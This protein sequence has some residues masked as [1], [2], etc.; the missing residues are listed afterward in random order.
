MDT[1]DGIMALRQALVD[2]LYDLD[3]TENRPHERR[4]AWELDPGVDDIDRAG[5]RS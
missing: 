2:E 4:L 5:P 3:G 1:L